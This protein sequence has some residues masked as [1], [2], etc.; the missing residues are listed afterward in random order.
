MK[1]LGGW[2]SEVFRHYVHLT[3]E[4]WSAYVR[5]MG[6]QSA[7]GTVPHRNLPIERVR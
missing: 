7:S 6:Q 3:R 4:Q 5:R 1:A 2:A